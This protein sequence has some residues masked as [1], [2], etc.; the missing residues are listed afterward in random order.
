[1]ATAAL[2]AVAIELVMQANLR[3][4]HFDNRTF[5]I[6]MV[7]YLGFAIYVFI[8]KTRLLKVPEG[9]GS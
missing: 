6:V 3:R 8:Q 5:M 4:T 1:M 2:L 7:A 9:S